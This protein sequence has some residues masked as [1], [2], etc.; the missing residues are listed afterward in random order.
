MHLEEDPGRIKRVGKSGEE[1][2]LIDYN[3]SGIPLVEI[4]TAP[5]LTSPE[6]ARNFLQELLVELRHIIGTTAGDEQ[7]VRVDANIS[8]GE[9]RVEVKN[10][11]GLRNLEKALKFEASRQ[12]KML[13]AG[14]KVIRETRRYDEERKVT[15][16]SREK[17]TEEDYGYIGEPDLGTFSVGDI[18][19]SM[20]TAGDAAATGA[21]HG[22]PLCIGLQQDAA[23]RAHLHAAGRPVRDARP[24]G[25]TGDRPGLDPR[26]DLGQLVSPAVAHGR[27][28]E[29]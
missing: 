7:S 11:Q 22:R 18:A 24:E 20:S 9:E 10:I 16:P 15:M 17:E 3:R 13:E 5:D 25:R 8:M 28:G 1:V 12:I 6:E 2:S 29:G 23:D 21:A 14:M 26:P 4:V 27:S 19:R